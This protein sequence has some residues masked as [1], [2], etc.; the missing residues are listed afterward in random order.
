MLQAER[1]GSEITT[2]QGTDARSRGLSKAT[3]E[4]SQDPNPG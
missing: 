3:E 4:Q 1:T 2:V